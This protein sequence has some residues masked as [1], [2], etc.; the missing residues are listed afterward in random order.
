MNRLILSALLT[1]LLLCTGLLPANAALVSY[2]ITGDVLVGY[3]LAH[4]DYGLFAGD[5][6]T[7]S[8]VFDDSPLSAGTGQ[9]DFDTLNGNS[10]T[11]MAGSE[12]LYDSNDLDLFSYLRF[13]NYQLSE[14]DY[15]AHAGEN[16]APS[17][18]RSALLGFDDLGVLEGEWRSNVEFAPVPVP[19]ALWLFGSGIL[20]L[21]ACARKQRG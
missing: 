20:G 7:V 15:Y 3:E 4:N 12:L 14:F 21:L 13:D 5:T 18:F 8:G 10:M 2:T 17:G 11:I 19:A 16:G 1:S 9:I 6:V